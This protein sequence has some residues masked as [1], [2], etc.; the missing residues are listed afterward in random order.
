ML[1][2]LDTDPYFFALRHLPKPSQE[3]FSLVEKI[4]LKKYEQLPNPIEHLIFE[5]IVDSKKIY[6]DFLE[7]K[8]YTLPNIL[9]SGYQIDFIKI[10]VETKKNGCYNFKFKCDKVE[11][12]GVVH[13]GKILNTFDKNDDGSFEFSASSK[14]LVTIAFV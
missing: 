11:T 10:P 1:T 2:L 6:Q 8:I 12:V 5:G 14:I 3:K 13:D 7:N 4:D 9:D